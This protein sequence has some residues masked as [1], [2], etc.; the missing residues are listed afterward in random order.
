MIHRMNDPIILKRTETGRGERNVIST[1]EL[2]SRIVMGCVRAIES[3]W[4]RPVNADPVKWDNKA[5]LGF[6]LG[7]DIRKDDRL[8][9][10]RNG[11]FVV[12][13]V[14][15]GRRFLA[16]TAIQEKRGAE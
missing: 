9:L 2:P 8:E 1:T 11:E 7:E 6:H 10:P 13:D 3:A 5:L 15:P 16:V 12:V 4:Q 14:I